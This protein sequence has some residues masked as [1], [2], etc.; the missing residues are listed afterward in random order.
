MEIFS[1]VVET[2]DVL[3]EYVE[4]H[5]LLFAGKDK[6]LVVESVKVEG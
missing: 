2:A 4:R 3:G 5:D 1:E 6:L